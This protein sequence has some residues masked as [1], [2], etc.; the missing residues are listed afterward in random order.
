MRD[1]KGLY[2]LGQ[3]MWKASQYMMSH[4]K[5]RLFE[6]RYYWSVLKRAFYSC[7]KFDASTELRYK[8]IFDVKDYAR[9]HS[10]QM[11]GFKHSVVGFYYSLLFRRSVSFIDKVMCLE[12]KFGWDSIQ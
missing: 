11:L 4:S 2:L 10:I 6:E 1:V 5:A 8:I 9:K 3:E 12:H 7:Y